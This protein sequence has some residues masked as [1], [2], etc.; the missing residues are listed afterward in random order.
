MKIIVG[1]GLPG[2]G[3]SG[4]L[5]RLSGLGYKH[6]SSSNLLTEHF[7]QKSFPTENDDAVYCMKNGTLVCDDVMLSLLSS[8]ILEHIELYNNNLSTEGIAID[9]FPR[10][11]SQAKMLDEF[12][13]A[14]QLSI[15]HSILFDISEKTS[16]QRTSTRRTGTERNDNGYSPTKR[17]QATYNEHI[18]QIIDMYNNQDK[19]T[20]I[21]A[22]KPKQE[23]RKDLIK[24]IL[25]YNNVPNHLLDTN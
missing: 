17:R 4:Q 16:T 24:T 9:G 5:S 15:S 19:L 22:E 18:G 14:H 8:K 1:L 21:D 2:S 12:L 20:V 10:T 13:N 7:C 6:I 25:P 11:L 3:K 23:T